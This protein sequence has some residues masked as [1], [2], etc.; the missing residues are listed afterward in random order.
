MRNFV[1]PGRTLTLPAPAAVKSGDGVLIG[2]IFGVANGDAA[3]G[4]AVDLDVE[5]VFTL[6]KVSA[7]A[8]APGDKV[9]W[10]ATDKAVS[11]TASGNTLIGVATTAAANPSAS[12]NVRLNG[13][14]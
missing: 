5:G 3:P 4:E 10:V 6:P 12:V 2:S 13:S 11:K 14:F 7:L 8:I 1:Q 9:Y